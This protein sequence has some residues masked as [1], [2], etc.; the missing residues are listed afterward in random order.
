MYIILNFHR[1]RKRD[2][3]YPDSAEDWIQI[4]TDPT[5]L[6]FYVILP[7]QYPGL[8]AASRTS[9]KWVLICWPRAPECRVRY[10]GA[11][12]QT[13]KRKGEDEYKAKAEDWATL[14]NELYNIPVEA[15]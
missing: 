9:E 1:W 7:L 5:I 3:E 15:H 12:A 8:Q 2:L 6:L 14:F 13:W 4:Q 11:I 10:E